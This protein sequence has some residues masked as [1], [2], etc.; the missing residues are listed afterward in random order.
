MATLTDLRTELQEDYLRMPSGVFTTN[1]IDRAIN[2]WYQRVQRDLWFGDS[3]N[4][5]TNTQSTSQWTTEYS[6]PSDYVRV[7]QVLLDTNPL[8]KLTYEEY[9]T[10]IAGSGS[11]SQWKPYA[12]YLRGANIGLYWTPDSTYSLK[13][14]YYKYLATITTSQDSLLPEVCNPCILAYAAYRSL[15]PVGKRDLAADFRGMYQDELNQVRS[16]LLFNDTNMSFT[17]N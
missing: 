10:M 12:Y 16:Q 5:T 14:V 4:E 2:R 17:N 7:S 13:I 15:V 3:S 1:S 9:N 11:V 6:L 8:D